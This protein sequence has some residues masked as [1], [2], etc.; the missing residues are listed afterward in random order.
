MMGK[1]QR[2]AHLKVY[3]KRLYIKDGGCLLMVSG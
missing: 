2:I 3:A 1:G